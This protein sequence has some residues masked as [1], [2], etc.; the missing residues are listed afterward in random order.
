L[1]LFLQE[2][3]EAALITIRFLTMFSGQGWSLLYSF[4]YW[5]TRWYLEL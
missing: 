2:S 3:A 5:S 1:D 4:V